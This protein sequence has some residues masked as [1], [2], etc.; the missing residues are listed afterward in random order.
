[1]SNLFADFGDDDT[2]VSTDD[3]FGLGIDNAFATSPSTTS[4]DTDFD[5]WSGSS[6]STSTTGSVTASPTGAPPVGVA[7]TNQG[8]APAPPPPPVQYYTP[9]PS[10]AASA[11]APPPVPP[12]NASGQDAGFW[13]GFTNTLTGKSTTTTAAKAATTTS[14]V[15]TWV[16]I[17]G[18]S[19][20]GVAAL[21]FVFATA[22]GS[23]RRVNGYKRNKRSRRSR[24]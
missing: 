14:A 7:Q 18:A 8:A 9:P 11:G 6:S 15:P 20:V 10:V 4:G 5:T 16:W 1:M 12:A 13:T 3:P 21:T 17:V 22:N 23:R 24:R 2:G 19:A